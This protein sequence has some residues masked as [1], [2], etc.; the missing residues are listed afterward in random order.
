MLFNFG[1]TVPESTHNMNTFKSTDIR[2]IKNINVLSIALQ[3]N[4]ICQNLKNSVS[5][6]PQ[7][8]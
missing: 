7:Q 4:I 2:V 5:I 1:F 8:K 6:S 3:L